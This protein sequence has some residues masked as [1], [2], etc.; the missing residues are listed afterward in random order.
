MSTS[1]STGGVGA[2]AG[3]GGRTC[4]AGLGVACWLWA[5]VD[6]ML[7][8][9]PAGEGGCEAGLFPLAK[10]PE[11]AREEGAVAGAL[12]AAAMEEAEVYGPREAEAPSGTDDTVL[13]VSSQSSKSA[14]LVLDMVGGLAPGLGG[15]AV[16]FGG[17]FDILGYNGSSRRYGSDCRRIR[18]S[19]VERWARQRRGLSA[20]WLCMSE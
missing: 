5:G 3:V 8:V 9:L 11:G 10:L 13:V 12:A 4:T 7:T 19:D 16:F 2:G 18:E 6:P 17:G 14:L 20:K 1:I 15:I